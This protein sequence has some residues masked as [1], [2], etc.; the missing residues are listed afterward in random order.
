MSSCL[1]EEESVHPQRGNSCVSQSKSVRIS[2]KAQASM[3]VDEALQMLVWGRRY[4]TKILPLGSSF[5]AFC[6]GCSIFS[7]P[8]LPNIPSGDRGMHSSSRQRKLNGVRGRHTINQRR[9]DLA[10][11]RLGVSSK[12][13]I[14]VD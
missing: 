11:L 8:G 10:E 2:A 6:D 5:S 14:N 4:S 9:V 13:N 12:E 1:S 3:H 7:E